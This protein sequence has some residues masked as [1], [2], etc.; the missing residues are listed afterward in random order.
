M[1][2]E[3]TAK[4]LNNLLRYEP[5][6]G[7]LFWLP[8][9]QHWFSNERQCKAWN[10]R[11]ANKE[12]LTAT[13]G[14]GYR[15]GSVLGKNYQAHRLIWLMM[16]GKWPTQ[17][18]HK[19]GIRN[20]N[21]WE[22]LRNVSHTENTRNARK[23]HDNTSGCSGVTFHKST[24]KWQ[25]RIGTGKGPKHL[26]VFETKDEAIEARKRAERELGY[27]ENHGRSINV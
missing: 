9:S 15:F 14:D 7:K 2:E 19:N 13:M 10:T 27:H 4:I 25:V 23:R 26:G 3:V 22:N 24:N 20:D 5:L 18:D 1:N 21:R 17:T 6:T 12:A 16:T 11:C 8:R